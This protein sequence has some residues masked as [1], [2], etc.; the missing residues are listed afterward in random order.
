MPATYDL[1]AKTT[2]TSAA[3][4]ITFTSI[5]STF[6]DL[7]ISIFYVPNDTAGPTVLMRLNNDTSNSYYGL[8]GPY[9]VNNQAAA[10]QANNVSYIP[11]GRATSLGDNTS[12]VGIGIIDVF[13]YTSA[14]RKCVLATVGSPNG[15]NYRGIEIDGG[16]WN[17]TSAI[18]RIDFSVNSSNMAIGTRIAIY[19]IL[20]A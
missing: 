15:T 19:G 14:Y 10:A 8:Q 7:Q 11:L 4:T 20:R 13:S 2:L 18:N 3:S 6:T 16:F 9:W 12:G 5:P 17:D 1:I